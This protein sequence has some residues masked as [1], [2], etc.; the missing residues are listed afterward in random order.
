MRARIRRGVTS[1]VIGGLLVVGLAGCEYLVP[2][3]VIQVND[4]VGVDTNIGG[5]DIRDVVLVM[6]KGALSGDAANLVASFLASGSSAVEL[7]VTVGHE[8]A[9]T[10]T[11]EPGSVVTIGRPSGEV[12]LFGSVDT[13]PGGLAQVTF[14]TASTSTTVDV[15]VLTDD[16]SGYAGLGPRSVG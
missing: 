13:R 3:G 4:T 11:V 12:L 9:Q 10:V 14:S 7:Q 6:D 5:V 1:L 15:P 16:V 8:P 2:Q